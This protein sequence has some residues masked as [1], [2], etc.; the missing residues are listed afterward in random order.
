MIAFEDAYKTVMDAVYYEMSTER[1]PLKNS[2]YRILAKD[3]TSDI[4]MPPFPKSAMDG[5]ACRKEDI[6]NELEVLEIIAAGKKPEKA[7]EKNQCSKIMTGAMLPEGAD[8]VIKVEDTEEVG[9]QKISFVAEDTKSNF[10]PQ[11]DDAKVGDIVLKKGTFIRPQH[12]A[13]CAAVGYDNPRVFKKIR[14]GVISTGDELVEPHETPGTSQI[15][16][17]NAYQLIAQL[18]KINVTPLYF[19]IARDNEE[20]T[21]K[22]VV[23]A[24]DDCDVVLLTGGVSMGDFDF[25]PKIFDQLEV[26]IKFKAIAIQPGKPTVFGVLKNK[27]IFGLPGNPVSSFNIFELLVKPLVFKMMGNAYNPPQIK[28][29]LGATYQRKKSLRRS[30]L[31]VKVENGKVWPIDYHGSAHIFALT[32][33]TGL[34]SIPVG[35]SELKE[36]EVV[37]V[38]QI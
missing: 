24:L 10:V 7:I 35:I 3:I 21:R 26:D 30:F 29:P 16:N 13:V 28:L 17:T 36:G 25:I 33:A 4:D 15:R 27:F 11:G 5:Y 32:E 22:T 19:G 37:D 38:R 34:I 9:E 12:I 2:L 1:V 18:Q 31:P 8:C 20:S 14:V 23:K 6:K